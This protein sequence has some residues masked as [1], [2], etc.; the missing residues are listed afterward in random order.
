MLGEKA[1]A[2]KASDIIKQERET[3]FFRP[4]DKSPMEDN[5]LIQHL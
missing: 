4:S 1:E 3:R 2:S 5:R